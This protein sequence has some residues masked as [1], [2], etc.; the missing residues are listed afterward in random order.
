M[1]VPDIHDDYV[2]Q[3]PPGRVGETGDVAALVRFLAGPESSRITGTCI[4][5]DGGY[6]LRRGPKL[7]PVMQMLH[8]DDMAP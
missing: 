4:S 8:G 2:D 6:H 1:S 3:M 5:A 7:D